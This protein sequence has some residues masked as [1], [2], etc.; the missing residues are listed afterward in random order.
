M[1][2]F[3]SRNDPTMTSKATNDV[4]VSSRYKV[5]SEDERESQERILAP[6]IT[7]QREVTVQHGL[8]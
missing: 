5:E 6:G 3:S 7:V 8:A 4:Y 1:H 2:T